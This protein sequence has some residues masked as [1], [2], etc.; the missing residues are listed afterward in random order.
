MSGTFF[1]VFF[2]IPLLP[3]AIQA[4]T[5]QTPLDLY[6]DRARTIVIAECLRVGPVNIL[7]RAS[8]DVKILLVV[9][10]KETLREISVVS[11]HEMVPGKRYLL[12]TASEATPD[13]RYFSTVERNSVIEISESETIDEIKTLS[14]RIIVLRAMNLRAYRLESKIRSLNY[15]LEAI[16]A[17][18]RED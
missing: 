15:E 3:L 6:I 13:G 2:S 4:Q 5:K 12:T 11:H 18:R 9:K 1:F 8:T 17:A 16:N 7:M 14:P 10:G